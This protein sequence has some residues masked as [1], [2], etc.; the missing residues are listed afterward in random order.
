M[1]TLFCW[2]A[3]TLLVACAILEF[4]QWRVIGT[5]LLILF[6]AVLCL[7]LLLDL[8]HGVTKLGQAAYNSDLRTLPILL[9]F[10][11]IAILAALR[12]AWRWLFWIVWL[13]GAALCSIAI[14]LTFFWKVF[15]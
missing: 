13:I 11:A 10:L 14:Y 5:R 9:I 6:P 15:S 8:S 3:I 12:S 7:S 4:T 2:F 1:A